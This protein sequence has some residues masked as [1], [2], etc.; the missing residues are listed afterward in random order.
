MSARGPVEALVARWRLWWPSGS[1]GGPVEAPAAQAWCGE[2]CGCLGSAPSGGSPGRVDLTPQ[3][4]FFSF[5]RFF[6]RF[7]RSLWTLL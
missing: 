7:S 3:L 6:H 2:R 1:S 5:A 4:D